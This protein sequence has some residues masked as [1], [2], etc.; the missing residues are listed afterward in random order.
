MSEFETYFVCES[1]N[2]EWRQLFQGYAKFYKTELTDEIADNVWKWLL[3][4]G[5]VLEG[6]IVRD[7]GRTAL[8]FLHFRSCPRP[9]SGCDMGF[10]DDMFIAPHARGSGAADALFERLGT[11]AEERNW[12][13]VR[14]VTQHYNERGRGLYDRYTAGPSD[15]IMYQWHPNTAG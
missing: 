1:D 2:A 14:W 9:L 13:V 12:P 8:G 3:D 11:I 10:A 6:L 5:H 4:S 15:F 7:R